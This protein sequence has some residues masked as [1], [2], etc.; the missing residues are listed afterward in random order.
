MSLSEIAAWLANVDSEGCTDEEFAETF[1]LMNKIKKEERND[2]VV[3]TE[4]MLNFNAKEFA[5]WLADCLDEIIF[6]EEV[7]QS[8]W[9]KQKEAV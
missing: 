3:E 2:V 7:D 9:W 6:S 4:D 8:A 5:E 1:V